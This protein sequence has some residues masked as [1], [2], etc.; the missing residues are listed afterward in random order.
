MFLQF[1]V[2]VRHIILQLDN[3][4]S[5]C[6]VLVQKRLDAV[7]SGERFLLVLMNRKNVFRWRLAL[8]YN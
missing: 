7:T 1:S 8:Q 5:T 6:S 4:Y 2:K 3:R